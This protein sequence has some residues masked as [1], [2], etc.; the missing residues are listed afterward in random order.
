MHNSLFF[1]RKL[2]HS[3]RVQFAHRLATQRVANPKSMVPRLRVQCLMQ[4]YPHGAFLWRSPNASTNWTWLWLMPN[5][6]ITRTPHS[7]LERF[8]RCYA[9]VVRTNLT[10]DS[11]LLHHIT[12]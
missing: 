5:N 9:A 7:A 6:D 4:A 11:I 1:G 10:F 3:A 8:P 12:P 2:V